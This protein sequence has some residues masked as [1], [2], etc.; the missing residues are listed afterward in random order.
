[1][2]APGA[3]EKDTGTAARGGLC[4]LLVASSETFLK[5]GCDSQR[6]YSCDNKDRGED[7][8]FDGCTRFILINTEMA[9]NPNNQIKD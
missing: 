3:R 8:V 4:S 2:G 6:K 7:K 9:N 1:M 5:C